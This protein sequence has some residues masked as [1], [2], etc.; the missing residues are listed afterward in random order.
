MR[1]RW[2]PGD[3]AMAIGIFV[4]VFAALVAGTEHA[5]QMRGVIGAWIA[6]VGVVVLVAG[7]GRLV[8]E[9]PEGRRQRRGGRWVD[10]VRPSTIKV[11][12]D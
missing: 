10:L 2:Q 3:A 11:V 8:G 9:K 5:D 12:C 7:S 4:L 6:V 1:G